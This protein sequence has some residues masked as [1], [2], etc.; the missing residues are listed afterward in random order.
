[1]RVANVELRVRLDEYC[2]NWK[3]ELV[4]PFATPAVTNPSPCR[5]VNP[6]A[7]PGVMVDGDYTR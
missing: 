2:Q 5:N 3:C 7:L 6:F 1:M 4:A